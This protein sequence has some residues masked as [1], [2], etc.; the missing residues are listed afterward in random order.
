MG[1]DLIDVLPGLH[2]PELDASLTRQ[3]TALYMEGELPYPC[4]DR[5]HSE[6]GKRCFD[7]DLLNSIMVRLRGTLSESER[8]NLFALARKHLERKNLLIYVADESVMNVAH[9]QKWDGAIPPVRQDFLM[10]VDSSLPGYTT[11]AIARSI[12]YDLDLNPGGVSTAELRVRYRNERSVTGQACRQAEGGGGKCYWNYMRIFIPQSAR[13]IYVPPI[14]LHE[15]SEKLIWGH[16]DL[17]SLRVLPH[18]SGGLQDLTEIGGFITVERQATLTVP[19]SYNLDD[20]VVRQLAPGTFEYRLQLIKQPGMDRDQVTVRIEL[21]SGY[22]LVTA[23]N[24]SLDPDFSAVVYHGVLN[25]DTE[26]VIVFKLGK[27][28]LPG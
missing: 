26:I 19:I 14:P 8:T 23:I 4:T 1:L 3:Q 10:V 22:Q 20:Q 25:Q 5:H 17:D 2:V 24:A 18:A 27:S 6:R 11:A 9:S 13:D 12:E 16:R 7:E 21:P 15:G 28:E